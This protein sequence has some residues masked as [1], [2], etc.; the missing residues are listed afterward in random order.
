GHR[1]ETVRTD[2]PV[3]PRSRPRL[4]PQESFRNVPAFSKDSTAGRILASW[5]CGRQPH[6]GGS[7]KIRPFV[8]SVAGALA[9][10]ALWPPS[11]TTRAQALTQHTGI[12]ACA[13]VHGV[14]K[15]TERFQDVRLAEAE[16]YVLQFGCVSGGDYGAMGLHYVNF[17]L[18]LEGVL[19]PARPEIILYEP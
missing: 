4:A 8:C 14:S 6:P 15:S 10:A 3:A 17:P 5:S 18:S 7:M 1:D 16:G 13:L 11:Q 12:Q 9:F 2:T 19:D